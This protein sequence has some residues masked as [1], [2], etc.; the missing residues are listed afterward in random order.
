MGPYSELLHEDER[1]FLVE[2]PSKIPLKANDRL[3]S[4][5]F[6]SWFL[7][8]YAPSV[9]EKVCRSLTVDQR[10]FLLVPKTPL[11]EPPDP[12]RQTTCSEHSI[13]IRHPW[14]DGLI[15]VTERSGRKG[16]ASPCWLDGA[17]TNAYRCD[18]LIGDAFSQ[19]SCTCLGDVILFQS[20]SPPS[21]NEKLELE[22]VG[23]SFGFRSGYWKCHERS[24]QKKAKTELSPELLWG[25]SNG[26]QGLILE[27]G[28]KYEVDFSEGYSY[29]LFLD[30]RENR[31]RLR[32]N[33][34]GHGLPV[35]SEEREGPPHVLNTFA[36]TCGFS[37]CAG[38]A[39]AKLVSVD[40]SRKYL[41]WGKRN[42]E[43]NG[44][45]PSEHEF[46]YGDVFG[47]IK[48]FRRRERRFD[49]V[50]LDPPTFSRSKE[51]GVFRVSQDLE[52]LVG[53]V[54]PLLN[55]GGRLFISSNAATWPPHIFVD[56]MT[57]AVRRC[58]RRIKTQVFAT[59][60]WDF[61]IVSADEAYLK[62]QWIELSD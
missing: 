48:R 27:S 2:K 13:G 41:E 23:K 12:I 39:G 33:L 36:Y 1:C 21:E 8:R 5:G 3:G 7:R 55:P 14:I 11:S 16:S 60:P 4:E 20:V 53:M 50:I 10:E 43:L 29:G 59:Q 62:T 49:L 32:H 45:D 18:S 40:L 34:V 37:V 15:E 51:W 54:V 19:W 35:F 17:E 61:G 58:G 42:F 28:V 47:W 31:Y 9:S 22:R 46:L 25:E 24:I 56:A 44:L 38:L 52:K 26:D 57:S 30:Q 6:I